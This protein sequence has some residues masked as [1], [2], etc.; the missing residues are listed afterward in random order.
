M[1][2]RGSVL[3]AGPRWLLGRVVPRGVQRLKGSLQC[4]PIAIPFIDPPR[5]SAV[6]DAECIGR[7][8][9]IDSRSRREVLSTAPT[10]RSPRVRAD[11]PHRSDPACLGDG[12]APFPRRRSA[13]VQRLRYASANGHVPNRPP[14]PSSSS[15]G[16]PAPAPRLGSL[17]VERVPRLGAARILIPQWGEDGKP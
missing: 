4:G 5:R 12:P 11:S 13:A 15:V 16:P 9:T 8:M 2:R 1:S 6:T 7:Q 17:L 3:E 14:S 10:A